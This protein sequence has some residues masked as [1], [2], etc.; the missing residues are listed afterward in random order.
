LLP[1]LLWRLPV[2]LWRL[3]EQL[4]QLLS[5]LTWMRELR[6]LHRYRHRRLNMLL[7]ASR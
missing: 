4:S 5:V 2:L 7:Q 6:Q 1:V 3:P